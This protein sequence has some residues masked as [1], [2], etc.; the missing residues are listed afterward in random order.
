[1]SGRVIATADKK[2]LKKFR[3]ESIHK[4]AQVRTD[5]WTGYR[6]LEAESPN[7]KCGKGKNFSQLHR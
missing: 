4:D 5:G 2:N 7:L 3:S 6:G 1:M